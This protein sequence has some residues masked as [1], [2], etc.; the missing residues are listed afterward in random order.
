[1][2]FLDYINGINVEEIRLAEVVNNIL[3]CHFE[4]LISINGYDGDDFLEFIATF[5]F[6]VVEVKNK[7][8]ESFGFVQVQVSFL[9]LVK[10]CENG[11]DVPHCFNCMVPGFLL[12]T[13]FI[14]FVKNG[15]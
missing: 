2:W 13:F 8:K 1:M 12:N 5:L 15:Q 6:F 14:I 10:N 7:L 3:F 9:V 4:L 11:R